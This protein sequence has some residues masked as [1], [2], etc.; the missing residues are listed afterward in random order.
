M[1]EIESIFRERGVLV[2]EE[3]IDA[4][5]LDKCYEASFRVLVERVYG[6]D[7]MTGRRLDKKRY[8]TYSYI[9]YC[10]GMHKGNKDT[11]EKQ[12]SGR[13]ERGG[14]SPGQL[15]KLCRYAHEGGLINEKRLNE[16]FGKIPHGTWLIFGTNAA[17][18][19]SETSMAHR[20]DVLTTSMNTNNRAV[21][22]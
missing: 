4:R 14:P 21:P 7:A 20:C 18:N 3:Q 17:T 1:K 15:R 22:H 11:R 5:N 8:G 6:S 10:N 19:R 12:D 9:P 16:Q 2:V 13:E